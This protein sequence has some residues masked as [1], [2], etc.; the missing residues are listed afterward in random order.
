MVNAVP[1]ERNDVTDAR[2]IN[3]ICW[4][5]GTSCNVKTR[6]HW[7]TMRCDRSSRVAFDV[8]DVRFFKIWAYG[9]K[10]LDAIENP[11]PNYRLCRFAGFSS[12]C[13]RCLYGSATAE[14]V[15]DTQSS[16]LRLRYFTTLSSMNSSR[17]TYPICQTSLPSLSF[18]YDD[19]RR[20]LCVHGLAMTDWRHVRQSISTVQSTSITS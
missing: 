1:F 6:W 15:D 4:I 3:W 16:R 19:Y 5:S 2:L 8:R 18:Y 12:H 11:A 10:N 20:A 14:V 17:R 13:R 9:F 7:F